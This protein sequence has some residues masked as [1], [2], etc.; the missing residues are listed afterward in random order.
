M[1]SANVSSAD[2]IAALMQRLNTI[3]T[4]FDAISEKQ[5]QHQDTIAQ[6][7]VDR[8]NIAATHEK[9]EACDQR[10][11]AKFDGLLDKAKEMLIKKGLGDKL[12]VPK[13]VAG[14]Q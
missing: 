12:K 5:V 2:R 6:C 14:N 10:I 8:D 4:N 11:R 7:Q 9:L 1:V 13:G 3:Q